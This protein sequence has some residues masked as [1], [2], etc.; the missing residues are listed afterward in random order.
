M[1]RTARA[2]DTDR[3]AAFLSFSSA[4]TGFDEFRLRGTGQAEAYLAAADQGAGRVVTDELLEAWGGLREECGYDADV[5]D[6]MLRARVFSDERLGP[7][8]RAI[9]KMWFIGTW[10]ALPAQ[11]QRAHGSGT[12][13]A[14]FVV[15][16]AAYTE[17]LLWPAVGATPP[18]AKAPGY[19][20]WT[21]PPRIPG[22]RDL[23]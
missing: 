13:V 11:W 15:S 16:P 12:P 18:G 23:P 17:G 4:T 21:G 7:P 2:S 5:R 19:A 1:A 10:Y 20:S 6:R 22:H 8:A 9:V 14:T 3:T